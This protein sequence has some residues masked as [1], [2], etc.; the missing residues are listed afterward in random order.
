MNRSLFVPDWRDQVVFS[1][2]GPQPQVLHDDGRIKVVV[3]ALEP[4]GQ[5]PVHPAEAGV[6]HFLEGTGQMHVGEECFDLQAGSTVV[7]PDGRPR[8]IS[9]RD[10]LAFIAVRVAG[11]GRD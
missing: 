11:I 8:G 2:Q 6:Y 1:S 7:V 9:A 3:V 10:R 4:G 5:I